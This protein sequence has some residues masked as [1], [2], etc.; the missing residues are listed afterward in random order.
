MYPISLPKFGLTAVDD[1][2]TPRMLE[3]ARDGE[4]EG[5]EINFSGMKKRFYEL[6]GFDSEKD[7]P[8]KSKLEDYGIG[9]KAKKVW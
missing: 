7:I 4:P 9:E 2:L 3:P 1:E 8:V 5:I 6:A